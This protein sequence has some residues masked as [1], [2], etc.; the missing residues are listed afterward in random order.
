VPSAAASASSFSRSVVCKVA[1]DCEVLLI[2]IVID[3]VCKGTRS[4]VCKVA[5]DCEVLIIIIVIDVVCKGTVKVHIIVID[6]V[7]KGTY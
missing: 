3:V 4:V 1:F 7:C 6:V 2:I 5:F